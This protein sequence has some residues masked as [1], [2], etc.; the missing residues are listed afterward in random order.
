MTS[1]TSASRHLFSLAAIGGIEHVKG[2]A[3][4]SPNAAVDVVEARVLKGAEANTSRSL[5]VRFM[6][7]G[8]LLWLGAVID[9]ESAYRLKRSTVA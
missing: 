2:R 4:L 3:P 6:F 9:S 1:F 7:T 5:Q 8:V